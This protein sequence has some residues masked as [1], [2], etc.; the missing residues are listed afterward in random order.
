MIE[1]DKTPDIISSN[2]I[3]LKI[4]ETIMALKGKYESKTMEILWKIPDYT[5]LILWVL[6]DKICKGQSLIVNF[7]KLFIEHWKYFTSQMIPPMNQA[8]LKEAIS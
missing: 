8:E 4:G 5:W 1:S 3:C 7:E 2:E 6:L